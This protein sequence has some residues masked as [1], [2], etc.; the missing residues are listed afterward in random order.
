MSQITFCT[1]NLRNWVNT[2]VIISGKTD[3]NPI[4]ALLADTGPTIGISAKDLLMSFSGSMPGP[5]QE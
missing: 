5:T 2:S 3:V 1:Y 4:A